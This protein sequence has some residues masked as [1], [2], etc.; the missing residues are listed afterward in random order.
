LNAAKAKAD[1]LDDI[2]EK[3]GGVLGFLAVRELKGDVNKMLPRL[4]EMGLSTKMMAL[5]TGLTENAIAIRFSRLKKPAPKKGSKPKV[6]SE[7][8]N[9]AASAPIPDAVSPVDGAQDSSVTP[10]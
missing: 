9:K 2:N 5:I 7:V 4:K 1:V 6:K 3:L 10:E 8:S